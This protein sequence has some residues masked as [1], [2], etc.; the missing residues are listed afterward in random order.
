MKFKR[1]TYIMA[2]GLFSLGLM[3]GCQP[4]KGTLNEK[5]AVQ[6]DTLNTQEGQGEGPIGEGDKG[7]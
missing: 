2:I 7:V 6:G 1:F 5:E 3:I 4:D